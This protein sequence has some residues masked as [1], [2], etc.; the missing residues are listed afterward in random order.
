MD[1]QLK[2]RVGRHDAFDRL[3][4]VFADDV[5]GYS[6]RYAEEQPR[7]CGSGRPVDLSAAVYATITLELARAH[8][9][10]GRPT[11]EERALEPGLPVVRAATLSCDFE[12]RVEW[13]VG[14]E[15]RVPLRVLALSAPARLVVDFRHRP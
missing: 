6:V 10:E 14:L 15:R 3:V 1:T 4:L 8:N 7:Q 5:P 11:V 12:G 2:V 13:V 9:E